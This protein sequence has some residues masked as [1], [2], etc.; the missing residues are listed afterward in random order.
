MRRPVG[1]LE[2]EVCVGASLLGSGGT[3]PFVLTHPRD[4]CRSLP[5]GFI[6][7]LIMRK[8]LPAIFEALQGELLHDA[9]CALIYGLHKWE[10][11]GRPDRITAFTE[12]WSLQSFAA[13]VDQGR[14]LIDQEWRPK[15]D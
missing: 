6:A 3:S 11:K 7:G 4:F 8:S 10:T 1:T 13:A 5:A 2:V 9:L 12:T 14:E 15:L